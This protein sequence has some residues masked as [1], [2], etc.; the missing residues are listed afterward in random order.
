[1]TARPIFLQLDFWR[2]P[3]QPGS[4]IDVRVPFASIQAVKMFLET[5]KLSYSIMIEDVQALLD[6]EQ[7][8]MFAFQAQAANTDTFNYAIYHKLDEVLRPF[9]GHCLLPSA[10]ALHPI[11]EL[12][13]GQGSGFA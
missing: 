6:E 11:A 10:Q 1:M 9:Q 2:G 4:F 3:A 5:N 7:E 13:Q 12:S 8:Q